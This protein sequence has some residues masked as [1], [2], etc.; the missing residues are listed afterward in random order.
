MV[1]PLPEVD[2]EFILLPGKGFIEYAYLERIAIV[3]ESGGTVKQALATAYAEMMLRVH[4][5][6]GDDRCLCPGCYAIALRRA[7]SVAHE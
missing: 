6:Q 7:K 2:D 1:P 4:S 5:I 3:L